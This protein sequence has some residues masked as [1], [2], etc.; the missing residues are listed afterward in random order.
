MKPFVLAILLP[1]PALAEEADLWLDNLAVL[2]LPATERDRR[3]IAVTRLG[4]IALPTGRVI[5]VDPYTVWGLTPFDRRVIP[6]SYPVY[7]WFDAAEPTRP[8]LAELR[9]RACTPIYWQNAAPEGE[10]LFDLAENEAFGY[11]VDAG[12]GSF[13]APEFFETFGMTDDGYLEGEAYYAFSEGLLLDLASPGDTGIPQDFVV[14]NDGQ[15]MA[16]FSSGWG[17]GFYFSY[18]GFDP[19]GCPCTLVT[20]FGVLDRGYPYD[21]PIPRLPGPTALKAPRFALWG[22]DSACAES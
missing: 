22:R 13:A 2:Q 4:T 1:L 8:A 18:W 3:G 5:A 19:Q 10:S 9:L 15:D 14:Q 11:G 6:G 7:L 16:V 20:D 17:D 21:S 12:A